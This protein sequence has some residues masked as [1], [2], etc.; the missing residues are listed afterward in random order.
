MGPS[1]QK[2]L[3]QENFIAYLP[4]IVCA[5]NC[6]G[7]SVQV[8]Q[9]GLALMGECAKFGFH[10]MQPSLPH[11]FAAASENLIDVPGAVGGNAG[12]AIGELGL[13]SSPDFLRPI[14]PNIAEKLV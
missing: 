9:A 11:L 8:Q 3:E 7:Y 14:L 6:K 10:Y 1:I 5:N 4:D 13:K 2:V 12:W